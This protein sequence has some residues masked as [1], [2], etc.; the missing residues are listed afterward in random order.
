MD[1]GVDI[2]VSTPDRLERHRNKENLY[3]SMTSYIVIDECDTFLDSGFKEKI[4]EYI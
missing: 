4:E 1:E 2:V 3:L